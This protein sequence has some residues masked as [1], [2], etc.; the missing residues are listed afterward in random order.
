MEE[1]AIFRLSEGVEK[2]QGEEDAEE[3]RSEDAPLFNTA[4]DWEGARTGSVVL[5]SSVHVIMEGRDQLK[6]LRGTS[7]PV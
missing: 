3:C 4:L 7:S 5:N 6:E 2:Q 1:D